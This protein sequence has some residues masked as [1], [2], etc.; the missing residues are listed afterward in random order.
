MPTENEN[1]E[2]QESQEEETLDDY[3]FTSDDLVTEIKIFPQ[4]GQ[5]Y[6]TLVGLAAKANEIKIDIP[7][8]I[9]QN[10]SSCIVYTYILSFFIFWDS[11]AASFL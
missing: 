3:L 9:T 11:M 6:L 7:F 10:Q 5:P 4:S 8:L 2:N 1:I